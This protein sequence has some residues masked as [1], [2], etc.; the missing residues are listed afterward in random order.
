MLPRIVPT[1]NAATRNCLVKELTDGGAVIIPG[2]RVTALGP[3]RVTYVKDGGEETA[4]VETVVVAVGGQPLDGLYQALQDQVM[5]LH[6]IGDARTP[7][8][9]MEAVREGFF[10]AYYI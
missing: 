2:A 7:R 1:M 4:E 10:T 5:D 3:G 6:V 9:I 8:K